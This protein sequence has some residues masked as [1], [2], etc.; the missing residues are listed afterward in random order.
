M[1]PEDMLGLVQTVDY[2]EDGRHLHRDLRR[3]FK[4]RAMA[5]GIATQVVKEGTTGEV[6]VSRKRSLDRKSVIGWNLFTGMYFKAGGL[7]W[8]PEGLP[9]DTCLIGV[10]FFRPLGETSTLRTSVVQAFDEDGDGLVLR[11]HD[12]HWDEQRQGRQPH[13]S[14]DDSVAVVN[15]VLDR[16]R[17]DHGGRGPGRVVVHKGS[18]FRRG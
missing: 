9:R 6:V 18:R 2:S 12:F 7:P 8:S 11:G 17:A 5:H 16:Y 3:T 15:M 4:A 14:A 10:S 1:M 13:L